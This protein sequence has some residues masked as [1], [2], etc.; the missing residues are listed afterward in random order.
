[1]TSTCIPELTFQGSASAY[2]LIEHMKASLGI[3]TEYHSTLLQQVP[4]DIS[5]CD[6]TIWCER[7]LYKLSKSAGIVIS[8]GL[9]VSKSLKNG[10]RLK[11]LA[12]Q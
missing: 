2:Q 10:V 8:L 5:S 1:V 6:T 3:T 11:D 4:I 12:F 7:D 9:C